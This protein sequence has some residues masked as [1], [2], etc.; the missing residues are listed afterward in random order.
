MRR[1]LLIVLLAPVCVLPAL[2]ATPENPIGYR[3]NGNGHHPEATIPLHF[4]DGTAVQIDYRETF[5]V[6]EKPNRAKKV[7][8]VSDTKVSNIAWKTPLPSWGNT[9]PIATHGRVFV[10]GEPNRLFC[11]DAKDGRILWNRE[12]NPWACAGV[13]AAKAEKA[14]RLWELAV[15]GEPFWVRMTD[16]GTMCNVFA[17]DRITPV[18]TAYVQAVQPRLLAAIQELD[19]QGDH[20]A[21]ARTTLEAV[22]LLP[23]GGKVDGKALGAFRTALLKRVEAIAGRKD[24]PLDIPWENLVGN[25]TSV[26]VSDG[27]RVY[28]TFGQDQIAAWTLDG[29]PVWGTWLVRKEHAGFGKNANCGHIPSPVLADGILMVNQDYMTLTGLNAATGKVVWTFTGGDYS[30]ATAK[31]VRLPRKDGAPLCVVV[32]PLGRIV[33][34]ADGVQVGDLGVPYERRSNW[35]VGQSIMAQ[36]DLVLKNG[37]GFRLTVGDAGAVGVAEIFRQTWGGGASFSHNGHQVYGGNLSSLDDGR[38]LLA[39]GKKEVISQ[40]GTGSGNLMVGKHLLLMEAGY[41]LYGQNAAFQFVDLSGPTPQVLPAVS[42]LTY[43]KPTHPVMARYAP[44]LLAFD[45]Y[46]NHSAGFPYYFTCCDTPF[47]AA[48]NALFVR[49]NSHLYCITEGGFRP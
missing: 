32:T 22:K 49:S 45:G 19:P 21:A 2:D 41:D 8:G 31:V 48:G 23:D 24:I 35:S 7:W 15:Y 25:A 47:T 38:N 9:Q 12:A 11:L 43:G 17:K 29:A 26:P 20:A 36:G 27:V 30:V 46:C 42:V 10:K 16:S 18:V 34:V 39:L 33:R 14:Q 44:E 6:G 1:L 40:P 3:G 28:A 37:T 4:G 13:E 5:Q